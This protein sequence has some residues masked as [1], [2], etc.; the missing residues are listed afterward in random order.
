[1]ENITLHLGGPL[2]L[3]AV[4]ADR[5]LQAGAGPGRNDGKVSFPETGVAA[6]RQI[7]RKG[8]LWGW[9]VAAKTSVKNTSPPAIRWFYM[10]L[11]A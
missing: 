5:L 4:P 3:P 7:V 8:R 2:L 9:A 11:L 1:M 10:G 6:D